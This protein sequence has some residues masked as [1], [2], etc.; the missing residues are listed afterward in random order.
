MFNAN[1]SSPQ[2]PLTNKLPGVLADWHQ[3]IKH[4][5][6]Y[7]YWHH[8][9]ITGK[10][11]YLFLPQ[12]QFRNSDHLNCAPIIQIAMCASIMRLMC[13]LAFSCCLIKSVLLSEIMFFACFPKKKKQ[14]I[15]WTQPGSPVSLWLTKFQTFEEA[16]HAALLTIPALRILSVHFARTMQKEIL[17]C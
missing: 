5:K 15:P 1:L 14:L 4:S 8:G 17:S 9:K 13:T 3:L 12:I 11:K 16:R 2:E 6:P 10:T 7:S